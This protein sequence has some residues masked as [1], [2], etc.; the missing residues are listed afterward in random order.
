MSVLLKPP[1]GFPLKETIFVT[2]AW[3]KLASFFLQLTGMWWSNTA[4]IRAVY[5]I[6]D[7]GKTLKSTSHLQA[8]GVVTH[9]D[10][11]PVTACDL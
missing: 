4:S 7:N 6:P 10:I 2:S 11:V 1:A 9:L 3:C 8:G 5:K